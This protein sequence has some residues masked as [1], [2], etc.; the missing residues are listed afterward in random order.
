MPTVP[1]GADTFYYSWHTPAVGADI[2]TWD[3]ILNALF[4]EDGAGGATDGVDEVIGD[5]ETAL[6]TLKTTID[7]VGTRIDTLED[8]VPVPIG[9][10][11]ELSSGQSIPSNTATQLDLTSVVFDEGATTTVADTITVPT[12]GEGIWMFRAQVTGLRYA[13]NATGDDDGRF[14]LIE[15]MK[16]GTAVAHGRVPYID[17][18]ADSV[19]SDDVSVGVSFLDSPAAADA[20]TVRV[21]QNA[22]N[23]DPG[24]TTVAA[25]TGTYFEGVRI[26]ADPTP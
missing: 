11:I 12:G 14:W 4:G 23:A 20:Y 15:I 2:G 3:T 21:T 10:R 6:D 1:N 9:S 18:G 5:L 8:N 25:D 16:N 26:L 19:D 22:L 24:A 7:N 17:D 13:P